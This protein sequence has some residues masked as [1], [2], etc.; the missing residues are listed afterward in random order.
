VCAPTQVNVSRMWE[1]MK[2]TDYT[3]LGNRQRFLCSNASACR[4]ACFANAR[5]SICHEEQINTSDIA[6]AVAISTG[7]SFSNGVAS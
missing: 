1:A 2:A 7:L 5:S 6:N 4:A 3:S